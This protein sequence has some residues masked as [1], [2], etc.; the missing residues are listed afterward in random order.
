[1]DRI[2][3]T[4]A[5]LSDIAKRADVSPAAASRVLNHDTSFAVS[6]QVRLKIMK[7]A[8]ECG[9]KTPRQKKEEYKIMEVGIADWHSIPQSRL[10]EF[11]YDSL[12]PLSETEIDYVFTRLEKGK[13]REVDAII[14]IGIFSKE[15]IDELMFSSTNIVFL[16]N[17][18]ENIPFDRMFIDYDVPLRKALDYLLKK[19]KK[20][21]AF[22][23][24]ISKE[25]GIVIGQRRLDGVKKLF[26]EK[27][28]YNEDLI[29]VGDLS[30]E[31]GK[32]LMKMAHEKK[33]DAIILGS[34]LIEEGVMEE[35]RKLKKPPEIVLRRDIDLGYSKVD[36]PVIRMATEQLWRITLML[37]YMRS[38]RNQPPLTV[39][40]EAAFEE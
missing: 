9:Y 4:M 6:N 16:N 34:E 38:K 14:G 26:K 8:I 13:V 17:R 15:E 21:I 7:A 18:D 2:Q 23:S 37:I 25:N 11:N 28:I 5:T 10:G 32:L 39:Y 1:M 35:Y 30:N 27:G 12:I 33:A 29:F 31:S 3:R 24:G 22:I 36:Y 40:I 20:R 19:E